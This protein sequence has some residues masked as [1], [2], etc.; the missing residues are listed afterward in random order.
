MLVPSASSTSGPPSKKADHPSNREETP[1]AL[2][3]TP[4]RT[5]DDPVRMYS[6]FHSDGP[7]SYQQTTPRPPRQPGPGAHNPDHFYQQ[8]TKDAQDQHG[9]ERAPQEPAPP[10]PQGPRA[11]PS[12]PG[13]PPAQ[14]QPPDSTQPPA[15]PAPADPS[16][17][18][19][20]RPLQ[21]SS[22]SG[23]A[24]VQA[25]QQWQQPPPDL[26]SYYFHRPLY[27]GYQSQYPSPYPPDPGTAP[28]YYQV[29][30]NSGGRTL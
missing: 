28:L 25:D 21:S 11:E 12:N 26:A 2:D 6:L 13:S 18:L 29:G 27:D 3:L 1:G 19:P 15:G 30:L 22:S 16:Q 4:H 20:P 17:Q 10:P 14:G 7:A 23:P 8:V 24:A 5:L 9:L